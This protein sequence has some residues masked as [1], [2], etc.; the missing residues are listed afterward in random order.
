MRPAAC[1]AEDMDVHACRAACG[2]RP[3]EAAGYEVA[4][5]LELLAADRA[6]PRRRWRGGPAAGAA[7]DVHDPV[8]LAREELRAHALSGAEEGGAEGAGPLARK[9]KPAL[10]ALLP[11]PDLRA[12]GSEGGRDEDGGADRRR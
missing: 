3:V 11:A 6:E 7:E 9:R 10:V 12:R 8:A 2:G 5:P 4:F 1:A